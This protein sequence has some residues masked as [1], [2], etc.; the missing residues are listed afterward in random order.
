MVFL[1]GC[2]VDFVSFLPG[3]E[4]VCSACCGD[5]SSF[6]HFT[7]TEY[8]AA[9]QGETWV[10]TEITMKLHKSSPTKKNQLFFSFFTGDHMMKGNLHCSQDTV[11]LTSKQ[12]KVK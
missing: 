10:L 3:E 4:V 7:D 2:S 6:L 5:D 12:N 9:I 1:D 8:P 11:T